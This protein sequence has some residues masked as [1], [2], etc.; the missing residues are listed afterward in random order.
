[1]LCRG[2][3]TRH[4]LEMVIAMQAPVAA[5]V[6]VGELADSAYLE[7]LLTAGYPALS[8]GMLVYMLHRWRGSNSIRLSKGNMASQ[9]FDLSSTNG[10]MPGYGD[11][12]SY[13]MEVSLPSQCRVNKIQSAA[14]MPFGQCR[15][16]A[17]TTE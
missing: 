1:M 4:S 3:G 2:H 16:L 11:Q 15:R 14:Q 12:Y 9:P 13:S 8:S 17:P 6:S 5:I 10:A 7:P